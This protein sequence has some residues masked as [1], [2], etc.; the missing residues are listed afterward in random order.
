MASGVEH[1]F[2]CLFS[3][4]IS[5]SMKYL[6]MYFAHFLIDCGFL[7]L[8]FKNSLCVLSTDIWFIN[9]FYPS[10]ACVFILLTGSFACDKV[11][12]I[13]FSF[14]GSCFRSKKSLHGPKT[15]SCFPLSFETLV[16]VF[17]CLVLA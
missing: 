2:M 4:C 15:F 17:F 1:L 6:F 14:Y 8:S 5:S 9:T 7:L 12:F 3:I 10:M 13:H 11:K 16:M